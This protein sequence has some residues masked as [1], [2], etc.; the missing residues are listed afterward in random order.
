VVPQHSCHVANG[1]W[2]KFVFIAVA[3]KI[4][5]LWD[6]TCSLVDSNNLS[7]Y[8]V[9]HR[10]RQYSAVKKKTEAILKLRLDILEHLKFWPAAPQL[11]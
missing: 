3:V 7:D 1:I 2:K 8:R 9:S 5:V 10:R 4:I 11:C 6:V